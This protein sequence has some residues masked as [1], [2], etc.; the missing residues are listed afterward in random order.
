MYHSPAKQRWK[1]AMR[2]VVLAHPADFDGWRAA[3]RALA[4][5]GVPAA[6]VTWE[7]AGEQ[8]DLLSAV[9]LPAPADSASFTVPRRFVELAQAV[10]C[11][12][13]P[14]RF[15]LLYEVLTRLRDQPRLIDDRADPLVNRLEG[16][17]RS[18]ARDIHKMRAFVRFREVRDDDGERYV[19]WFEPEH[20]I[21]RRNAGFFA[22]R[23]ANMRWSILT[24][25]L[26]VHWDGD[27]LDFTPGAARTD[28]P[29]GDEL[30]ATWRTYYASIFNPARLKV[31]AMTKEMPKKY[32]RNLPET[33]L[34]PALV[35]S[36]GSRTDAMIEKAKPMARDDRTD[37]APAY[38]SLADAKGAALACTRCDLFKNATQTVF[39]VGE[40]TA[41]LMF[42]GE[43]PGDQEDLAGKPF[44]GPAGKVF[45]RALADA[46]IERGDAYVTNAVKHFKFVPRGSRR[47]HQKPDGPEIDACRFWLRHE[48]ALIKPKLTVALGATA[49]RSLL[50]KVVTIAKTRGQ[51][52]ELAD[53]SECWVTV[54]PS[55]LLRI[56]DKDAA[57]LEYR[58]FVA[59]LAR[60]KARLAELTAA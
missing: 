54:H 51:P 23:F 46:G 13:D 43:A 41:P 60:V 42:V 3:A 48:R 8:G 10:I 34:V 15:G 36:A 50:G 44:V 22:R 21:V 14:Q 1:P 53:G 31:R 9:S 12:R 45:D 19:A 2:V 28:A 25:D 56:E 59:D 37:D 27:E 55:F 18:V 26:C 17:E 40:A 30:E 35:A 57:D 6:D 52:I 29:D 38:D 7:V 4:G 58:R 49:A 47:I 11:H 33:S 20:H 24:P 39:G 16:M 5:S 32:W